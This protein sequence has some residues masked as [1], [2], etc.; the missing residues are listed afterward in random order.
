ML[1]SLLFSLI[2]SLLAKGIDAIMDDLLG[3]LDMSMGA[4][5]NTFPVVIEFYEI[6][7]AVAMGIVLGVG[8]FQLIRFFG[9]R[10]NEMRESPVQL[11]VNMAIA[12]VFIY[13]GNYLLSWLIDL[14]N[15]PY[16]M[17]ISKVGTVSF[18]EMIEYVHMED[19]NILDLL[20]ELFNPVS[21]AIDVIIWTVCLFLIVYH[22]CKIMLEVVERYI[23]LCVLMYTSPLAW[24]TLASNATRPIFKKWLNM[25]I[26]ACLMILLSAWSLV[27][28]FSTL[29]YAA[30]S[31][32]MT[33]LFFVALSKIA[34]RMDNILQTLG[35]N[36]VITGAGLFEDIMVG[37]GA[38][39]TATRGARQ[40]AANTLSGAR[41]GGNAPTSQGGTMGGAGHPYGGGN[42]TG[43]GAPSSSQGNGNELGSGQNAE[44]QSGASN[45]EGGAPD[46][47][48][49]ESMTQAENDMNTGSN[50]SPYADADDNA[51]GG[52]MEGAQGGQGSGEAVVTDDNDDVNA[53]RAAMEGDTSSGAELSPDDVSTQDSAM[54][55]EDRTGNGA[56]MMEEDSSGNGAAMIEE[57]PSG[58]GA[59]MIEED[60]S[61]N[62]ATTMEEDS[63]AHA[64]V[65]TADED[66]AHDAVSQEAPSTVQSA[67]KLAADDSNGARAAV[68]AADGESSGKAP[69]TGNEP[70][71]NAVSGYTDTQ[72]PR[73]SANVGDSRMVSK[74][75]SPA[76]PVVSERT[77]ERRETTTKS[78]SERVVTGT[79][80]YDPTNASPASKPQGTKRVR[81]RSRGK[82]NPS[83]PL[84]ED[85]NNQKK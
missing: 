20:F 77:S 33:T 38:I 11:L 32:V 44:L 70:Q 21:V 46:T 57:N 40:A 84:T 64:A 4:F 30:E 75:Y 43:T 12:V 1:A 34:Q 72:M 65:M 73:D 81:T 26:S 31:I 76:Q 71:P 18:S 50:S 14:F 47:H 39:S 54:I 58:N 80:P 37:L 27:M 13:F 56:A 51:A 5:T 2:L 68:S 8:L 48:A 24:A 63:S 83:G 9:G 15:L 42:G 23:V 74:T 19:G 55:E 60:P 69:V 66:S 41:P 53:S 35:L 16:Q 25:F 29:K 6:L 62:G 67:D 7:Q 45:S 3:A 22:T 59:A 52:T 36:P 17:M 79:N 78:T 61:G 85:R 82:K 49:N 10:L 28:M